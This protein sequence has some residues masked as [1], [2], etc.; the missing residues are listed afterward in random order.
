[1]AENCCRS[2]TQRPYDLRM[3]ICPDTKNWTWVLER[4]CPECGFDA[5]MIAARDVATLLQ[6]NAEAWP[7]VLRRNDVTTRPNASTWSPLE[8]GAHVRD[9][10]R[11]FAERLALMLDV[12]GPRF[13]DWDQ[14]STAVSARYRE[15]DPSA[16]AT[17]L[18]AA[19]DRLAAAFRAV[20][21]GAWERRGFRSDG[22]EFTI[23]TLVRYFIHDP[24]H[25]LHDVET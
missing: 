6:K 19:A 14:D 23:E 10:S 7:V 20:P 1:M 18:T 4:Q 8:Y 11:I 15:Q 21:D 22:A 2:A 3:T 25:H 24:V 13:D 9:V 12:D 17:E 5:S 16:V